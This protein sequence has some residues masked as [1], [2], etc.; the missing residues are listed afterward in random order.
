LRT[1]EE[2]RQH[3]EIEK[4][5]ATRLRNSSR[6]ER[7]AMYTQVYDELFRRVP[8]H[9]QWTKQNTAHRDAQ[10]QGHVRLLKPFLT[11]DTVFMEVYPC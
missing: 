3:Y 4:E 8:K 7:A 9:P 6:G 11:P 5:L 10:L 1:A 2:L